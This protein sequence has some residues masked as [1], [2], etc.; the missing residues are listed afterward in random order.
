[1]QKLAITQFRT[2]IALKFSCCACAQVTAVKFGTNSVK[3]H[4][5]SC[6]KF[7][8]NQC[9]SLGDIAEQSCLLPKLECLTIF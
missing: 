2:L 4:V 1:M 5:D 6:Q 3:C 8:A 7:P 9:S